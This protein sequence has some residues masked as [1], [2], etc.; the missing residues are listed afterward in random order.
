MVSVS[1][2]LPAPEGTA[3]SGQAPLWV[4]VQATDGGARVAIAGARLIVH[5]A[6]KGNSRI[7][8]HIEKNE[9][10]I[11]IDSQPPWAKIGDYQSGRA[12][13]WVYQSLL[14]TPGG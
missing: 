10:V 6:P 11:I 12:L 2:G 7:V 9:Q 8:D 14:V 1:W 3:V 4:L 13:G 5:A